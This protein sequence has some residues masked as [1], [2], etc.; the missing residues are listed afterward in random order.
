[1][2][3]GAG[4][5]NVTATSTDVEN[6]VAEGQTEKVL[7]YKIEAVGSDVAVKSL[8]VTLENQNTAGSYRLSDYASEVKIYMGSTLVGNASVADFSRD[9]RVYT[10]SFALSNAIVREGSTHKATFYVEV[11]AASNI[12]SGDIGNNNWSLLVNDIRFQDATGATITSND[13]I[14]SDSVG[15]FSFTNL[16][17]LGSVKL[18]ISKDAASPS[19]G[20]VE[21]SDTASTS[22]VLMLEFKLKATGSDMTFD[23]LNVN[24]T[25]TTGSSLREMLGELTLMNGSDELASES[26]FDNDTSQTVTFDLGNTFTINQDS[27]ETF[28][29]LAKVNDIEA[30]GFVQGNGFK[31]DFTSA[32]ITA[33]DEN[34]D[35]VTNETGS[36]MGETQ[37]FYSEGISAS[38]FVAGTPQVQ[39]NGG[40]TV[41]ASWPISFKITAF[42]NDF[43][44]PKDGLEALVIGDPQATASIADLSASSN[45]GQSGNNWIVNDG[46]TVTFSTTGVIAGGTDISGFNAIELDT[47]RYGITSLATDSY[48]FTPASDFRTGSVFFTAMP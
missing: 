19:E 33:E 11:K 43:Y 6:E 18:T 48:S 10:R 38:N 30:P 26:V 15:Q 34:G 16:A 13:E 45:A 35:T 44:V 37:F 41:S 36:A 27:T 46:D 31:V 4:D 42:G 8:K 32:G 21:V 28:K 5:V 12:D 9:G 47:L 29:V 7:G 39:T 3:G 22:N 23:S 20:N 17:G 2:Q 14:G 25:G 40:A 24:L 1:L